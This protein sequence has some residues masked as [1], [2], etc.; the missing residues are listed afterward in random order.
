MASVTQVSQ[1]QKA[2]GGSSRPEVSR[3]Y[4]RLRRMSQKLEQAQK[5]LEQSALQEGAIEY[6]LNDDVKNDTSDSTTAPPVLSKLPSS[7]HT[8]KHK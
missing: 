4:A 8:I 5:K 6:L 7:K 3:K 1:E 2:S